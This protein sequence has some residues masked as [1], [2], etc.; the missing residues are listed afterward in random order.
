MPKLSKILFHIGI[1]EPSISFKYIARGA[2]HFVSLCDVDEISPSLRVGYISAFIRV[3][4]YTPQF[5]AV[6]DLRKRHDLGPP[7]HGMDLMFV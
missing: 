5:V 1:R 2:V 3:V 6:F 7:E 4:C